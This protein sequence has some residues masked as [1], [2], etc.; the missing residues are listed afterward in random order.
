MTGLSTGIST[1]VFND[2]KI[3]P[4]PVTTELTIDFGELLISRIDIVDILGRIVMSDISAENRKP[5]DVSALQSG[6]YF[7]RIVCDKGVVTEKF[8]KE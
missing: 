2:V 3:Y 7:V 5:V 6:I 4:N 8:I 1:A